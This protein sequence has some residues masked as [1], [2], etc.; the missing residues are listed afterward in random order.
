MSALYASRATN[1]TNGSEKGPIATPIDNV[2]VS[3]PERPQVDVQASGDHA[4]VLMDL[5]NGL[6]GWDSEDDPENPQ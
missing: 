5:D 6:V 3:A 2:D 1:S 4:H